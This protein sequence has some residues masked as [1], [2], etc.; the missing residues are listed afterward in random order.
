MRDKIKAKINEHIEGILSK[1]DITFE[2]YQVLSSELYKIEIAEKN[3][4][5]EEANNKR[6]EALKASFDAMMSK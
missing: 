1:D 4:E 5:L 6:T 3:K 2:D